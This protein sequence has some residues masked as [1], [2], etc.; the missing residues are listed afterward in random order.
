M[1]LTISSS[2]TQPLE[3][4]VAEPPIVK[5]RLKLAVILLDIVLGI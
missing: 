5:F 2:F 4:R 3:Q 1:V